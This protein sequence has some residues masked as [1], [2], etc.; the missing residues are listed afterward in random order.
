M[1]SRHGDSKLLSFA[2]RLLLF[3]ISLALLGGFLLSA[4]PWSASHAYPLTIPPP[5]DGLWLILLL[6]LLIAIVMARRPQAYIIA[7]VLAGLLSY[8]DQ[9]RWQPW[10]YQFLFMLGALSLYPWGR[11]DTNKREVTLNVCHLTVACAYLWSGLCL[12]S[13]QGPLPYQRSVTLCS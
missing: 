3:K 2:D 9:S 4:K 10:F 8:L 5:I 7:F 13:N 11:Q 12:G 6:P 1:G